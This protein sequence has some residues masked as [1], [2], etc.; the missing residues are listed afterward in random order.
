MDGDARK[1][2][3][4]DAACGVAWLQDSQILGTKYFKIPNPPLGIYC[5]EAC[6][7]VGDPREGVCGSWGALAVCL[8]WV[9]W[10]R[11]SSVEYHVASWGGGITAYSHLGR[12]TQDLVRE[13]SSPSCKHNIHVN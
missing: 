5:R 1:E 12:K 11:L 4:S 6:R 10:G 7:H 13:K 9:E 8:Q 2:Q 3:A